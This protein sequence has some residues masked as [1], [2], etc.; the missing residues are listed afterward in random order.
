MV[1]TSDEFNEKVTSYLNQ[2]AEWQL[3]DT[4]YYN[5]HYKRVLRIN[6]FYQRIMMKVKLIKLL[7]ISSN[8]KLVFLNII[9][10][11]F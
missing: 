5:T 9:K 1:Q 8:K 4:K 2:M 10:E 3:H 7:M 11:I 6:H